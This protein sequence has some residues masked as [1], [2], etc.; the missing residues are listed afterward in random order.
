[1]YRLETSSMPPS[2]NKTIN[3][4]ALL[5]DED[6]PP[7]TLVEADTPIV[8]TGPHNGFHVPQSLFEGK[9]PLGLHKSVFNPL[10]PFR[11]HEA[12][13][14]GL[15]RLFRAMQDNENK[16]KR[17]KCSYISG[18]YSRLVT[19]LNRTAMKSMDKQSS[20]TG[21]IIP[22]NN[23]LTKK[24]RHERVDLIHAPYHKAL[25]DLIKRKKKQHGYVVF[26]DLHSFTPVWQNKS[27]DVHL[28]TLAFYGNPVERF[29]AQ[30]VTEPCKA[31]GWNFVTHEPYNMNES[32]K[33]KQGIAKSIEKN[34][35]V[36]T[37]IEVRNDILKTHQ[38]AKKVCTIIT[39]AINAMMDVEDKSIFIP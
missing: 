31:N 18:N 8:I 12:C 2:D 26:L 30:K 39:K 11:R 32:S 34:G 36:Y 24:Q 21:N 1:M 29:I 38:C 7:F 28:G 17:H 20:E 14:W 33:S 9:K 16:Q 13:D 15:Y 25:A 27:R 3:K 4:T 10:S 35:T 19:D 37:G 6:P 22:G 23:S 5:T